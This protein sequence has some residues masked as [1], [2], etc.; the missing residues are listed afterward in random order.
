MIIF[1]MRNGKLIVAHVTPV[2]KS[3]R[4][5]CQKPNAGVDNVGAER[6]IATHSVDKL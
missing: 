1:T 4:N 2:Y 6:F 5:V 3:N